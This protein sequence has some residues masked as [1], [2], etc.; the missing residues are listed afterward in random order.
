M[1]NLDLKDAM[2]FE[3]KEVAATIEDLMAEVMDQAEIKEKK[4]DEMTVRK[5]MFALQYLEE[6]EKDLKRMKKAVMAEWDRRIN[7]KKEEAENI[8]AI[9]KSYIE[10]ENNGKPLKLDV[11]TVSQR[12]VPHKISIESEAKIREYLT[13]AGKIDNFLE[14]APLNTTLV[15]NYLMHEKIESL[16]EE[17]VKKRIEKEIQ[18]SEKGK[19]TKKR[20]KEIYLEV[21]NDMRDHLEKA[22][23]EGV[24]YVPASSSVS[25][26]FNK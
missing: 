24:E 14:P 1:I 17:E 5:M 23:P 19:I 18:A 16:I 2:E 6:E 10:K 20:E 22:L 3:K 12:R 11:G 13:K 26:K 4:L 7:K 8:K 25:I 21:E 15:K 9:L